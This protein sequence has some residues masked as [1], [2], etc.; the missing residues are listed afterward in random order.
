[1]NMDVG[2]IYH[3]SDSSA[4]TAT[5][6]NEPSRRTMARYSPSIWI[7]YLRRSL[8]R[9]RSPLHQ[10]WAYHR[11]DLDEYM[12]AGTLVFPVTPLDAKLQLFLSASTFWFFWLSVLFLWNQN[13][14]SNFVK[15]RIQRKEG[16][17]ELNTAP[18][19]SSKKSVPGLTWK[20][21][22][23]VRVSLTTHL[24]TVKNCSG[25]QKSVPIMPGMFLHIM[26]ALLSLCLNT[27][28]ASCRQQQRKWSTSIKP[29]QLTTC[30]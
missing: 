17:R 4:S 3:Y 15:H 18:P 5:P 26:S 6:L 9:C 21:S 1:M 14:W 7:N 10:I 24:G 23:V 29:H 16:K 11:R 22:P 12:N 25:G 13:I 20:F 27:L 8:S 19:L 30:S 2:V 28:R